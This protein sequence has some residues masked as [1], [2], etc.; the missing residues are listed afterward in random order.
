MA[1]I[2]DGIVLLVVAFCIWNGWRKGF[3]KALSRLLAFVVALLV[4][5]WCSGPVA[6]A[7]YDGAVAP[8]VEETLLTNLNDNALGSA[9]AKADAALNELPEYVRN[10]LSNQGIATG[11]DVLNK[12]GAT[13]N[14]PQLAERI[15]ATVV[16]P[17]LVPVLEVLAS[18]VLF[19]LASVVI[20]FALGLLDKV[21]KLP[22]LRGV[23]RTLGIIPGIINGVLCALILATV[24]QVWATTGT[25]DSLLNPTVLA[26]TTLL[27]W[28][29]SINP[30]G[31]TLQS[32]LSIG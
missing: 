18:F 28:L 11:Q 23:N 20:S 4:A 5:M 15:E 16:A 8:Q 9:S 32:L 30:L 13:D 10:L 25:A 29:V 24:A 1:Y 27:G 7:V 22:L 2:L 6:Q 12:V 31:D 21:F 26:D 14:A 19:L 17:L 3:I